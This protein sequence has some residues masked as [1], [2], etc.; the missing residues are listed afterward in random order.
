MEEEGK[1]ELLALGRAVKNA[2]SLKQNGL[3]QEG[4]AELC[5]VHRTYIGQ[6]ERGEKNL[7]FVN[8]LRISRALNLKPSE[9]LAQAGL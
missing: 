5:A 2:R 6:V 7:S 9:L 8:L 4:F 3:T 1:K